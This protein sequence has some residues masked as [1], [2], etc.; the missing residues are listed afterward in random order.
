M[1][2]VLPFLGSVRVVNFSKPNSDYSNINMHQS[3]QEIET[4]SNAANLN[5]LQQS[6]AS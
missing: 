3:D 2:S 4:L 5:H 1:I 6:T